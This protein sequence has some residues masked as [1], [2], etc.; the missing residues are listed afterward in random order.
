MKKTTAKYLGYAAIVLIASWGVALVGGVAY[1]GY[2][3]NFKRAWAAAVAAFHD[4]RAQQP[5]SLTQRAELA[6]QRIAQYKQTNGDP[7]YHT[8]TAHALRK[9]AKRPQLIELAMATEEQTGVDWQLLI[10]Q[11]CVETSCDD[12]LGTVSATEYFR[13]K[14]QSLANARWIAQQLGTTADELMVS[15]KGDFGLLQCQPGICRHYM[16]MMELDADDDGVVNPWSPAD[17]LAMQAR[18]LLD[19]G[20]M[21]GHYWPPLRRYKSGSDEIVPNTTAYCARIE[22]IKSSIEAAVNVG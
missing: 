17:A 5:A 20:Y 13:N 18:I 7:T 22:A 3:D 12:D 4:Q 2:G 21:A 14:P 16:Q 11:R 6:A 9:L 15:D 1:F 10:A 19:N 8:N